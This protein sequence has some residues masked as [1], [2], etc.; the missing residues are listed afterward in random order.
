MDSP[1]KFGLPPTNVDLNIFCSRNLDQ[2]LMRFLETTQ[3]RK[4]SSTQCTVASFLAEPH[5]TF[6][7]AY[8]VEFL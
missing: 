4:F 7:S 1:E 8:I 6:V 5:A 2:W 3:A